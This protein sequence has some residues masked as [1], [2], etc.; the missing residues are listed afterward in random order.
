L[1]RGFDHPG[2][3]PD[4]EIPGR[5]RAQ[6]APNFRKDLTI[7][8]VAPDGAYAA[9]S[10]M[11]VVPENR[12]AYVEPVATDPDFRRM[13]LGRAVVS[14]AI[15]RAFAEGAEVAWVGSGLEFYRAI[16]FRHGYRS[17]LWVAALDS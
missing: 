14:E 6:G 2:E 15:R 17:R 12:V 3:P 16:G 1:W 13:G 7:V 5:E 11:W 10:G 8:A 9:F 4:E